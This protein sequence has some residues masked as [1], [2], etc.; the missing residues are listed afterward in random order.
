VMAVA[1][2]AALQS[3]SFDGTPFVQSGRRPAAGRYF[4]FGEPGTA[5]SRLVING[6]A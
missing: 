2:V 4:D 6:A 1:G 3:V 5:T